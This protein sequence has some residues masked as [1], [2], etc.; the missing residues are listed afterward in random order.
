MC[1]QKEHPKL[2]LVI[3]SLLKE[4]ALSMRKLSALTGIDTA[5]IS[6]IASGKQTP[7]IEHLK[8]FASALDV[9]LKQLLVAIGLD[10]GQD[11]LD[12]DEKKSLNSDMH[13]L[14][15][16][17]DATHFVDV[18]HVATRV[19]KE[20][21][22]YEQYARTA[23]GQRVIQEQFPLKV[24]QVDGAGPFIERL[25]QMYEKLSDAHIS[26]KERSVI[27]SALLYFILTTDIIP[28]YLF[29]IG[30][31]DDAFAVQLVSERLETLN[32]TS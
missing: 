25:Q 12:L 26:D 31:L 22:N 10:L 13:L 23:E 3:K 17:L 28:D 14:V 7:K 19:K 5:T 29:P 27:G 4:R 24:Q 32:N 8:Q 20:L 1:E 18:Q 6:R 15:N 21:D 16:A 11:E 30:Y 2:G 9:P